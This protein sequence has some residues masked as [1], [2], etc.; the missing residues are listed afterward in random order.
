MT[1][2]SKFWIKAQEKINE[3]KNLDFLKLTMLLVLLIII[4][5]QIVKIQ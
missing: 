5:L 1:D 2:T 4:N 3:D